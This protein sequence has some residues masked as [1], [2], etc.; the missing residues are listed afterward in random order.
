MKERS[1]FEYVV[2]F[3]DVRDQTHVKTYYKRCTAK[4]AMNILKLTGLP[5]KFETKVRKS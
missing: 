2:T 1:Q 3:V 4:T 5:V